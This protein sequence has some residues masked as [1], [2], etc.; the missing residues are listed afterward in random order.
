MSFEAF[1][2]DLIT[3]VESRLDAVDVSEAS[4]QQLLMKGALYKM[5]AA[6]AEADLMGPSALRLL[7]TMNSSELGTWLAETSNREAFERILANSPASIAVSASSAIMAV[8]AANSTAITAFITNT[9]SLTAMLASSTAMTAVAASSTAM[10]ALI[11]NT[12]AVTAMLASSTAMT[13]VAASS[14][15]MT[16]ILGSTSTVT[17]MLAS[18][19]AMAVIA[20]SSTAMTALM[21]D[22]SARTALLASSTARAAIVPSSTGMAAIAASSSAMAVIAISTSVWLPD[23]KISTVALAAING[24]STAKDALR[25]S[26]ARTISTKSGDGWNDIVFHNGAVLFVRLSTPSAN[27]GTGVK[28]DGAYPGGAYAVNPAF[29]VTKYASQLAANWHDNGAEMIYIIC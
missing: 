10:G 8:I 14:T 19:A 17:A 11:G 9:T 1:R 21:G 25:Y 13:A 5:A 24:S 15:A 28:I 22:A 18:S 26:A 4:D 12:A 6:V 20:A 16:A 7:E 29:I 3:E 27:F 2:N 23:I